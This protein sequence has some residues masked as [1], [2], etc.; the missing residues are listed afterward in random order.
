M[1]E[2][3]EFDFSKPNDQEKFSELSEEQKVEI[4]SD[5]YDDAHIEKQSRELVDKI[6]TILFEL[7]ESCDPNDE[8]SIREALKIKKD[9]ESENNSI[10]DRTIE[11]TD[12]LRDK[13]IVLVDDSLT[14]LRYEVP[15]LTVATNGNFEPIH[16]Q[17]Q[18]I[19][20]IVEEILRK[21]PDVLL[22]DFT[23]SYDPALTGDEV[24][25][26]LREA[27]FSGKIVGYSSDT[28]NDSKFIE[29]GADFCV[30][31]GNT[32]YVREGKVNTIVDL[33]NKLEKA[34]A[35]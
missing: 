14:V 19:E 30:E 25:E 32:M 21:N 7:A 28:K 5:A 13:K 17:A 23:L 18:S 9:N 16:Y 22:M 29:A 24:I 20:K 8:R 34:E 11:G 4:E 31:K 2:K 27:G 15:Y 33:A 35:E 1:S 26:S 12:F 10:K 6:K 3:F